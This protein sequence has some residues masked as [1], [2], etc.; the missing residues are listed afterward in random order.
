MSH[1]HLATVVQFIADDY[2]VNK[3]NKLFDC[4]YEIKIDN[5]IGNPMEK[6]LILSVDEIFDG[7]QKEYIITDF[8]Y[9][10]NGADL[11]R[12][13]V[14]CPV[15]ETKKHIRGDNNS[16][17]IHWLEVTDYNGPKTLVTPSRTCSAKNY[18]YRNINGQEL[19][20]AF[21]ILDENYVPMYCFSDKASTRLNSYL[22]FCKVDDLTKVGKEWVHEDPLHYKTDKNGYEF[23]CH[24]KAHPY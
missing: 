7:T 6:L 10:E 14:L 17:N 23:L 20:S 4:L 21:K 5:Q 19:F 18:A 24:E 9:K 12:C 22:A 16:P 2:T 1:F 8:L 13:R 15:V 3:A 11:T